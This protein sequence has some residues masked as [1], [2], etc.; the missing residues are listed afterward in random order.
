VMFWGKKLM[1]HD[2][3]ADGL[4]TVVRESGFN[5]FCL[6]G[7]HSKANIDECARLGMK[8]V[9]M[10]Q[11]TWQKTGKDLTEALAAIYR[12]YRDY[13]NLFGWFTADEGNIGGSEAEFIERFGVLRTADPY[14]PIFRNDGGW[15]IGSGGPGG[16]ET[17]DI[18]LGGYGGHR[19]VDAINVDAVPRGVPSLTLAPLCSGDENSHY[20]TPAETVSWIYQCLVHGACGGFWWGTHDARPPVPAVRD[21]FARIRKEIDFLTPVFDTIPCE[22]G[23]RG[24]NTN[25]HFTLREHGGAFHLVCVNVSKEPQTA[26]F[27]FDASV[28]PA[29]GRAEVLFDGG[30]VSYRGSTLKASF[31][32]LE[33]RVYRMPGLTPPGGGR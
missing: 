18:F 3:P 13:P 11:V 23:A 17:T 29:R 8:I 28:L 6:W 33:R 32:P 24:D 21:A 15:V 20:P 27:T 31:A 19:L 5:V 7:N 25:V 2:M 14:H 4:E 16:L 9:P 1:G 10:P 12:E 26:V 30:A 22:T